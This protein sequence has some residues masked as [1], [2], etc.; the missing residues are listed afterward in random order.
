V[1]SAYGLVDWRTYWQTKVTVTHDAPTLST[2]W[3]RGGPALRLP[4]RDAVAVSLLSD[5]RRAS[6]WTIDASVARD[7]A[8]STWSASISP[9]LNIRS[10]DHVQWSAGPVYRLDTV[11][12]QPTG[13][14]ERGGEWWTVAR[15]AQR[16]L[17]ATARADIVLSPRLSVQLYAQPF[18]TTRRFDRPQ[19]VTAP[20]TGGVAPGGSAPPATQDRRFNGSVV[21]RWEYRAGS[22]LTVVWNQVR[23]AAATSD[24]NVR[25]AFGRV[26]DDPATNVLAIK[27]SLRL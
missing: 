21:L 24:A 6:Y 13:V 23:D 27:A 15:L 18:A 25:S 10:T 5:Q 4:A 12:W 2:S 7:P 3:L 17:A 19:F 20:F 26:F 9:L 11:A 22:F 14:A 16:T 1:L 8:P